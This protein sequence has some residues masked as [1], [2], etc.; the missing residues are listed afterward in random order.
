M[1]VRKDIVALSV[2]FTLGVALASASRGIFNH[3]YIVSAAC[4][5]ASAVLLCL[6]VRKGSR[7]PELSALFFVLGAF[8]WYNDRL[9]GSPAAKQPAFA[10]EGL[11]RLG[12]AIDGAG[13]RGAQTAALLKALLMGRR[14]S[15]DHATL[16]AFRTAGASHI[17]ALSGLH[18]G[19]IYGCISA[20]LRI[21]GNGRA[22]V[23]A[24]AALS[25]AICGSYAVMTGAGPSI[26][27][28]FLFISLNEISRLQP[29]RRRDPLAV[30]CTALLVQLCISPSVISTVEFQLSYLAMLGI[31]LVYPALDAW[32]PKSHR[33]D[34]MHRIWSSMALTISCQLF[35]APLVWIT[36]HS[37]PKYFLLTNLIALPLTEALM[38]CSVAALSLGVPEWCPEML[39]GL[40]DSLAQALIFCLNTI[41]S[42]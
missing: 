9:C 22:A 27:R 19:M 34:P 1:T 15:L 41:S 26:V 42:I 14:S 13:F 20:V 36:F 5:I 33:L 38:A 29:H 37:F 28:A 7:L 30:L 24:R 4:C 2:P 6:G 25:I 3:L 35:T 23:A 17:L 32:Y 39:K 12:A 8:C 16:E 11:E 31:F 21:F 10:L 18:L 40:V